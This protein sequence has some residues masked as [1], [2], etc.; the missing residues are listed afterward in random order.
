MGSLL[1]LKSGVPG[2]GPGTE[3]PA[4]TPG[5]T[6]YRS[7][8]IIAEDDPIMVQQ[9]SPGDYG[10]NERAIGLWMAPSMYRTISSGEELIIGVDAWKAGTVE[11]INSG[12]ERG[13]KEVQFS[14]NEGPWVTVSS[15][16]MHPTYGDVGYL[17][18]VKADD[19]S[20]S[21]P[22]EIRA[23]VVPWVGKPFILQ[24]R[25]AS[26]PAN[27][28]NST[29]LTDKTAGPR[30]Y[31]IDPRTVPGFDL[32]ATVS[33]VAAT[34]DVW[35]FIVNVSKTSSPMP[36]AAFYIDTVN[37]TGLASDS[38]NGLTRTTPVLTWAKAFDLA[39]A[40]ILAQ[41]DAGF[42]TFLNGA[43]EI[44][45]TTFY[46][47]GTADNHYLPSFS[48]SRSLYNCRYQN[49]T[50][51]RDPAL[52]YGAVKFSQ[53]LANP[54][55]VEKSYWVGLQFLNISQ[56]PAAS[57]TQW[58]CHGS[59]AYEDCFSDGGASNVVVSGEN[60][61]GTG[62]IYVG[63]PKGES[64]FRFYQVYGFPSGA[65]GHSAL[66]NC[67]ID[68][69]GYGNVW[70]CMT[71]ISGL[72][73]NN[74]NS[75][76]DLFGS[77]KYLNDVTVRGVESRQDIGGN[78]MDA[79]QPYG[80]GQMIIVKD[81]DGRDNRWQCIYWDGN[82]VM[83]DFAMIR[84]YFYGQHTL[85]VSSPLFNAIFL[86][87]TL[88]PSTDGQAN[89]SQLWPK[90]HASAPARAVRFIAEDAAAPV[91]Q[92]TF[93]VGL[94]YVVPGVTTQEPIDYIQST[95]FDLAS[96]YAVYDPTVPQMHTLTDV[97][98]VSRVT[99]IA[100]AKA[101]DEKYTQTTAARG[102][103][104]VSGIFTGSDGWRFTAANGGTVSNAD[105]NLNCTTAP[106]PMGLAGATEG[107]IW[108]IFNFREPDTGL[109][110][111]RGSRMM[112][113]PIKNRAR[114]TYEIV[115]SVRRMS[116]TITL[117]DA[118]FASVTVSSHALV[119]GL[120]VARMKL[121]AEKLGLTL[122]NSANPTGVSATES[123]FTGGRTKLTAASNGT[124]S[125]W[126]ASNSGFAATFVAHDLGAI[127]TTPR[128]DGS[129][130]VEA[131]MLAA[132]LGRIGL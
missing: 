86:R 29:Q 122:Y 55:Y 66:I 42:V 98:G 43:K 96:P 47:T 117:S 36:S 72:E 79:V 64:A 9:G 105:S 100:N 124:I 23:K 39:G 37:A 65:A 99:A 125:G 49:V 3:I 11:R 80:D 69:V 95:D 7:W 52:A 15:P 123:V 34:K 104:L 13:I 4:I 113:E 93:R 22:V 1:R 59:H 21:G 121:Y 24:G 78:H 128:L 41:I 111:N 90:D 130:S 38:N 129:P 50:Y 8:A 77:P 94:S 16:S 45:G 70:S 56:A 74:L 14:C 31:S 60:W 110:A 6:A 109:P 25:D 112:F 106:A 44:G 33:F 92:D 73:I 46:V 5:S 62:N 54:A 107:E 67:R 126:A 127:I 28:T 87:P 101:P 84:G 58:A 97:S 91:Y 30:G 26:G 115:S 57:N 83:T 131:D 2:A 114:I 20:A 61:G 51:R 18:R 71:L 63:L 120:Y 116:A 12:D 32:G 75:A 82:A 76:Y 48:S 81:F 102:P 40:A 19:F 35:S 85:S 17:V 10:Y 108:Y 53:K 103:E 118:S 88:T 89:A 132:C 68:N 119:N 27:A